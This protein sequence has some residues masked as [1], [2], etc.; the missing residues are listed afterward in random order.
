MSLYIN[1]RTINCQNHLNM[2][3]YTKSNDE[4]NNRKKTT[5]KGQKF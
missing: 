5:L 3:S 1:Q 4:N 2:Q